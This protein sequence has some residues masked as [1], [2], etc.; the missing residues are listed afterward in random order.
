MFNF[1][2]IAK[3]QTLAS[4]LYEG[5]KQLE[6]EE[7]IGEVLTIDEF[8]K[9][10][11]TEDGMIKE[12]GVLTFKEQPGYFYNTGLSFSNIID[13]WIAGFGDE[14]VDIYDRIE[15]S[16]EAYRESGDEIRVKFSETKTKGGNNFTKVEIL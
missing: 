5:R 16:N 11:I 7:I 13:A 12:Y 15:M 8:S 6:T 9:A 1:R 4:P 10:F 2:K 14:S 3:I